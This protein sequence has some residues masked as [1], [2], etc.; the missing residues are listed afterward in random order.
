MLAISLAAG[1]N[2]PRDRGHHVLGRRRPHVG[3]AAELL[4]VLLLAAY[5]HRTLSRPLLMHDMRPLTSRQP[6]GENNPPLE[7]RVRVAVLCGHLIPPR[8]EQG[9]SCRP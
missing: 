6:A 5:H 4:F 2:I 8:A 9:C 7:L 3:K 1:T